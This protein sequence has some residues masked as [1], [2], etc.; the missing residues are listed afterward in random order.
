MQG[1]DH[2]GGGDGDD[3]GWLKIPSRSPSIE[4]GRD[5]FEDGG[6]GDW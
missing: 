4:D 2:G 6:G 1:G 5:G 3:S